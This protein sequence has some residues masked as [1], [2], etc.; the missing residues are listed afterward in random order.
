MLNIIRY[1]GITEMS[2]KTAE[3]SMLTDWNAQQLLSVLVPYLEKYGKAK[4]SDIVK[5]IG[6]HISE[7]QLRN[8]LEQL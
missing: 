7:K 4:K 3:Y 8:F 2:G 5:I 1:I 6:S